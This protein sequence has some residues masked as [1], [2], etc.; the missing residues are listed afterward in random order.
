VTAEASISGGSYVVNLRQQNFGA[1]FSVNLNDSAGLIRSGGGTAS[2]VNAEF[3]VSIS[4]AAGVTAVKFVGGRAAGESGLRLT[5]TYGN[6]ILLTE[7]GNQTV[8]VGLTAVARITAGDL[9]FQVGANAGQQ[10]RLSLYDLGT[11]KLGTTAIAGKTLADVD[12]TAS[13]GADQAL[14]I[15]DAAIAQVSKLRGDMGAF[16]KNILES[17]LRSLNVAKENLTATESAI[18]DVNFAE[19]IASFTKYQILQQAG[20]SILGQANASPQQVLAL[21]R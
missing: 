3:S 9:Q 16:Q 6:V 21:L 19:E 20:M 15:I 17:N 1:N 12:V 4:T 11:T 18:R 5:D 2:G 7:Q 13:G 10:V 14:Q 8:G